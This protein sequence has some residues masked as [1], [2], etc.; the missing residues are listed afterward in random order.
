[1]LLH[2][3]YCY[4][5]GMCLHHSCSQGYRCP[6]S[7][8]PNSSHFLCFASQ[9]CSLDDLNLFWMNLFWMKLNPIHPVNAVQLNHINQ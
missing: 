3:I 8:L 6:Q 1:M 2:I 4:L 7:K 9:W 5:L